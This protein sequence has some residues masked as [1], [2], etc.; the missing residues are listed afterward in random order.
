MAARDFSQINNTLVRSRKMRGLPHQAKWAWLCAHL[1][2]NFLGLVEYPKSVWANEAEI[3]QTDMDATIHQLIDAGLIGWFPEHEVVRVVGFIKQRPPD[4]ASAATR[5]CLDLTDRLYAADAGLEAMLL[6]TSAEFAVASV[7]RSLRWNKDRPKFREEM[8]EFLRGTTNDF[9]D[10]FSE[11][12]LHEL[13]SAARPTR[14]ELEALL[15]TLS[16]HRQ[17]TVSTPSPHP[18]DTQDVDETRRRPDKNRDEE[19]DLYEASVDFGEL[20]Q[21]NGVVPD[22]G[23]AEKREKPQRPH[24]ETVAAARRMGS[25]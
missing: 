15:P 14:N 5:L 3:D 13:N 4:N 17:H 11:A 9:G 7:A 16:L 6:A 18:T 22:F 23:I 10:Q 1:K 8:G 2:A 25:L 20:A 21:P 19:K 24:P 12:L